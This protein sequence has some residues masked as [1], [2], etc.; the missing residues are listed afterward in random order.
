MKVV[1]TIV[2]WV[3]I[4]LS[5][6]IGGLLWA[7]N[8]I[9]KDKDINNIQ[10]KE[11]EK[12]KSGEKDV[13][14]PMPE[15]AKNIKINN[16]GKYISYESKGEM[17]IAS[18]KD[19]KVNKYEPEDN[20][21]PKYSFWIPNRDNM[22]VFAKSKKQGQNITTF[23]TY[24]AR[25]NRME[26]TPINE[27]SNP[28]TY[29]SNFDI[30]QVEYSTEPGVGYIRANI[31]GADKVYRYDRNNKHTRVKLPTTKITCMKSFQGLDD[32]AYMDNDTKSIKF[33]L[34]E[35]KKIKFAKDVTLL[36]IQVPENQ[37]QDYIYVGVL[38]GDKISEVL[39]G[40]KSQK[41]SEWKSVKLDSPVD[42]KDIYISTK[43]YIYVNNNLK[44][45][46]KN[47]TKNQE[48]QYEGKFISAYDGG[49]LSLKDG[50]AIKTNFSI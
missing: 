38:D 9:F 36:S 6:Q 7:E 11:M 26:W 43:G 27:S 24:N 31:Q 12:P 8:I 16:K 42:V 37:K 1:K 29:P 23:Y 48:L 41:T 35:P 47:Y 44:G 10:V 14:I 2:I 40:L 4:S 32:L 50:K 21:E 19:G 18:T 17:Y 28:R 15:D 34:V 49:V 3:L 22:H 30:K 46:I 45:S 13:D 33:A 25:K 5:I 20:H 39:Y